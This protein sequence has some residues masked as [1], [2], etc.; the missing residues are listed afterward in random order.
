MELPLLPP[1]LLLLPLP[2]ALLLAV[3]QELPLPLPL[4]PL[5]PPP[6]A[7]L[8]LLADTV[9]QLELL[10][11]LLRPGLPLLA[12][13]ALALA[14]LLALRLPAPAPPAPSL[15]PP[16]LALPQ[17]D[18][19]PLALL[20]R[21]LEP[22]VLELPLPQAEAVT[23]ALARARVEE[24]HMLPEALTEALPA[25]EEALALTALPEALGEPEAE[26]APRPSPALG[27]AALLPL[28]LTELLPVP[29]AAEALL[30]LLTAAALLLGQAE[31]LLLPL[32]LLLTRAEALR[33]GEPLAEKQA[34]ALTLELP[35]ELALGCPEE[36]LPALELPPMLPL[37]RAL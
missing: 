24:T 20:L 33:E 34:A 2:Q 17:R 22:P 27:E 6:S 3:P 29:G 25:L 21:L 28:P 10:A 9:E 16:L 32:L 30:L 31:G 36:L 26:P 18:T 35:L 15:P 13:E 12:T 8:L 14:L 37:P 11:L 4:P 1:L 7:P 19:A 23:E 5:P